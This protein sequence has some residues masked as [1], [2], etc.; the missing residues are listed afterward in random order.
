MKR[1]F[2]ILSKILIVPIVLILILVITSKLLE[3]KIVNKAI[4][5]LNQELN[6]PISVDNVSLSLLRNFPNATVELHNVVIES[7]KGLNRNDFESGIGRNLMSVKKVYLAFNIKSL[8]NQSF[9]LNKIILSKGYIN[10]L[11]DKKGVINYSLFNKKPANQESKKVKVLLNLMEL[12]NIEILFNNKFKDDKL[13]LSTQKLIARGR[14]YKSVYSASTQGKILFKEYSN[15]HIS[16]VPKNPSTI[17]LD[18]GVKNDTIIINN[19][20]FSTVGIKFKTKG[21]IVA[22]KKP[23]LDLLISGDNISVTSLL[24]FLP[25][26]FAFSKDINATGML[27]VSTRIQGEIS[28]KTSPKIKTVFHIDNGGM[29]HAKTDIKIEN[30]LLEGEYNNFRSPALT[31]SNFS[32]NSDSSS[33]H[34]K[35]S[36]SSI[37][38]P[39]LN[40]Q[41]DFHI[42]AN[43]IFHLFNLTGVDS[44][45]GNISG[46]FS[47]QGKLPEKIKF[48]NLTKFNNHGEI[49]VSNFNIKLSDSPINLANTKGNIVLQNDKI[50]INNAQGAFMGINSK[51]SGSVSNLFAAVNGSFESVYIDGT[52]SFD[53]MNYDIVKPLFIDDKDESHKKINYNIRT[54]IQIK[55]FEYDSFLA[56]NVSGNLSYINSILK[57]DNFNMYAFDGLIKSQIQ[58]TP[59]QSNMMVF[60]TSSTTHNI[61]INQIFNAFNNFNQSFVTHKNIKGRVTS[62]IDGEV[63][64]SGGKFVGQSVDLLGHIRITDGELIDFEP[65]QKLSSFSDINELKHLKFDKL[66]N[67][68]LISNGVI[69]IPRMDILSNAMDITLFGEQRLNGAFEYHIKLLLSDL[70]SKKNSRLEQKQSEFGII[71]DDGLGKTS[72]YLLATG[73]NGNTTVK[74][75]KKELRENMKTDFKDEKKELKQVLNEEFGWFGKDSLKKEEEPEQKQF[76]IEWDDD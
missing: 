52:A 43:D 58:L 46:Y 1:F 9:E 20:W 6:V 22:G 53:K 18:L 73:V 31:V 23:I 75:D 47:S 19:G 55:Q 74:F 15:S 32:F 17:K 71:E 5:A 48:S 72:I 67:D 69:N 41:S 12:N 36:L 38:N 60:K 33:F 14:F 21:Q 65:A 61:E 63:I 8:F 34:G 35:L 45:S 25:E 76:E 39:I 11:V 27:E 70:L 24:E 37:K 57:I 30:L 64:I 62:S 10:V 29:Q 68:I 50:L 28:E 16:F 49:S 2:K 4:V 7:S 40:I 66:E 42:N 51:C 13:V 59:S 56:E 3:E 44:L 26:S 54:K